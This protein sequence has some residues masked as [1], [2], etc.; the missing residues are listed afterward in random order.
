MLNFQ[1]TFSLTLPKFI[2]RETIDLS[3]NKITNIDENAFAPLESLKLLDLS[4]N[5]IRRVNVRLPNALQ[6]LTIA[7]NKLITWP[8]ANFPDSLTELALE[9]NQLEFIFPKDR[10]VNGL[11]TLDVSNN[12]IEQ[13]PNTQFFKLDILDLS[14]NQLTSVPQNLNTMAPLLRDLILDG[15]RISSV[16]FTEKTTLGRISLSKMSTLAR[17][18]AHAFTNLAGIK[19]R[20]DGNG[21][22]VDVHVTHIEN[23]TEIDEDA[24][25]GVDLC[26]LDL[27]YNQLVTLP[28]HLTDWSKVQDGIDLQG[29]PLSCNCEDQWMIE[30]ILN[31][32]YDNEDH[33]YYLKDL[34]CQSPEE[35]QEFRFVQFL[36]HESPFC[37]GF[38]ATRVLQQSK[39]LIHESSFGGVSFGSK[40]E[41]GTTFQIE[42]SQGPGFIIIIVMCALIL[43]AMILVGVRWQRDQ[44]RKLA[45][46]NRLYGYDY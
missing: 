28:K 3:Y 32:L 13:L 36:R 7:N 9:Y 35:L 25:E 8:L 42:L 24:F 38:S 43:L 1:F 46:R 10:E 37:G 21:T 19:V 17:L 45:A 18:D 20:Q 31:R 4:N 15:N 26:F 34:K 30:E 11:R 16:Y 29:N 2:F 22:C 39:T 33:Q 44:D 14:Y 5:N 41:D 27:S 23:L 12:L 40:P 6:L